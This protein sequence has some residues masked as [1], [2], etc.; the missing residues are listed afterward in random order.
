MERLWQ[1]S[2]LTGSV[3]DFS[4]PDEDITYQGPDLT[5]VE[6]SLSMYGDTCVGHRGSDVF[7]FGILTSDRAGFGVQTD[8]LTQDGTGVGMTNRQVL[9]AVDPRLN[10]LTYIYDNF[11][12]DHCAA[13]GHN[14]DALW[15]T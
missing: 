12:W 2:V 7:P 6:R 8:M 15:K 13:D 11:K 1:F 5:P 10:N 4:W 3:T 14:F 9:A